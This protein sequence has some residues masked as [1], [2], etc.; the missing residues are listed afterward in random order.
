MI[1][2][3]ELVE[4]VLVIEETAEAAMTR[5][6]SNIIPTRKDIAD[7]TA[8]FSMVLLPLDFDMAVSEVHCTMIPCLRLSAKKAGPQA[9]G[10]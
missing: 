2:Q 3:V 5:V 4:R 1:R 10:Y 7:A 8:S 9:R 6:E